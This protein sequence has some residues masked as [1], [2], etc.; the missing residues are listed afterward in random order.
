MP[1]HQ[2]DAAAALS[3]LPVELAEDAQL[4]QLVAS[5]LGTSSPDNTAAAVLVASWRERNV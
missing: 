1:A 4:T 3:Q 2:S 5:S